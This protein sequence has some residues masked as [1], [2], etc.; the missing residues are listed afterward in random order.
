[1]ANLQRD[2]VAIA[3]CYARKVSLDKNRKRFGKWARLAARRFLNDLDRC[4]RDAPPYVFSEWH[5]N[6]VCDFIEKLPHVEG[7]W[8][9][10]NIE[11][12]E[13]DVFFCV[14][15]FGFRT[16]AG[17]RRFSQALKCIA[18]K[19]AKSTLAACIGIYCETC[20]GEVGPQVIT[21]ATTGAQA[22]I[23]FNIAKRMV[24]S[25]SDLREAF[26]LEPFAN[27]IAC[28]DNG[29][30]FKPINAKA[31]SQ[32]GLNPSCVILDEI[33]AHKSHDLLNV[34]VSAAGARRNP[35][36]LFTTTEGY[37]SAGPWPELRHFAEQVLEGVVEADHFF[38]VIYSLDD[39]DKEA[40]TP[41]DDDF[42]ETAWGKANPLM[43]VNPL[44]LA[45]MRKQAIEAKQMP[46][47]HAEFK[48]KR[49]N[50]RESAQGRWVNLTK[51]KACKGG[52]DLKWLKGFPCRGGLDLATVSDLASFRL[53]WLIEGRWY[54]MGWR[55]VPRAAV[56]RRS[57]RGLVP[58][59]HWVQS[60]H[61]IEMGDETLDYDLIVQHI[62]ALRDQGFDIR[63]I[64][65]D[66]WNAS[67]PAKKLEE[68][69]IVM[70]PFIQG[71]KSY[72]PAM[73]ELERAYTAQELH[74]G[75]DPVLN[76]CISNVVARYDANMNQAPDKKRATEK[77]DDASALLMSIGVTIGTEEEASI[78]DAL[79]SPVVG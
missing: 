17:T 44:L 59:A 9:T 36:F 75:N 46:G 6:D 70:T 56:K 31:S 13:S 49:L 68:A 27:A 32:D 37:E 62:L 77:I 63:N 64:G 3:Q 16:H 39:E 12:H 22:R 66:T 21:G 71:A 67:Q 50:R 35:L 30:T 65:Y 47:R 29:G 43:D 58:F 7:K 18:R 48:I 4:E 15:L 38:C 76:W 40:K 24:E 10:K 69:G 34:L 78:L 11:L 53:S 73:K 26:S 55:Y 5:A 23:V 60:G 1:M 61:L 42:D 41:A 19:N 74:H 2:F 52:I 54:T 14:A 57:E 28:Y 51:W 20:E 72:H 25:T 33:H 45:E 79:R 8:D